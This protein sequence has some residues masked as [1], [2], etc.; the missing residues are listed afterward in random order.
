MLKNLLNIDNVLVNK[1]VLTEK[2][3]CDLDKCKGA[4]CTME[5]DYG[6]PLLEEEIA[7]IETVLPLVKKHLLPE[8]IKEIE[9]NGF[10]FEIDGEIMVS[11]VNNR[12]CVFAYYD[13]DIAKCAIEKVYYD[14]GTSFIKPLSCHL[15]PI[16][17]NRFG[18]DVLKY[19]VYPECSSAVALG[20]TTGI[21][22]AEFCN[23]GLK[24]KYGSKWYQKLVNQ[25]VK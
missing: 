10:Y 22:V 18:G 24:R 3:T 21:S 25:K 9:E 19:E 16:R 11:A 12:E 15:F 2:F 17:I 13:G 1:D 5:S 20:K 7:E 6:A 8:Q 23:S 14:E 4:C